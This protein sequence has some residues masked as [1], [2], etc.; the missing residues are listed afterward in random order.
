MQGTAVLIFQPAEERGQVHAKDMIAE[1]VLD[2]V[3][4][5]F[6]VHVVH[7]IK[8][9]RCN[10]AVKGLPSALNYLGLNTVFMYTIF[11]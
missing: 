5:I 9:L 6:G 2:N 11:S 10:M 7:L 8:R 3:D 1:R 4:A